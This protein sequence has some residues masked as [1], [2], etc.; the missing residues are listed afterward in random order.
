MQ[1]GFG[2]AIQAAQFRC[3]QVSAGEKP[4]QGRGGEFN[5]QGFIPRMIYAMPPGAFFFPPSERVAQRQSAH[6]AEQEHVSL[7]G[8]LEWRA[9]SCVE[10]ST[11]E[12]EPKAP[13]A[14]RR[15]RCISCNENN[16]EPLS[17]LN[18]FPP[19]TTDVVYKFAM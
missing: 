18:I 11:H 6:L 8:E 7:S 2:R 10:P 13:S 19:E 9:S 1:A 15:N 4:R 16:S 3:P 5:S 12:R 14:T 17:N